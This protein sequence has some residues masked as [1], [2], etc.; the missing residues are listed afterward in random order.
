[1]S[2][3][4]PGELVRCGTAL[5]RESLTN[6]IAVITSSSY[7]E[8][9][10]GSSFGEK[11]AIICHRIRE[12]WKWA[13]EK[14]RTTHRLSIVSHCTAD[15]FWTSSEHSVVHVG[16]WLDTRLNSLQLEWGGII[17]FGFFEVLFVGIPLYL[18]PD[19]FLVN[20]RLRIQSNYEEIFWELQSC[21]RRGVGITQCFL[22]AV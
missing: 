16:E 6:A 11:S 9:K 3:L 18:T 20:L 22:M 4:W 8:Q 14:C 19:C 13:K 10:P 17:S 1:M 5:A 2:P 7:G 15:I 12:R 21:Y